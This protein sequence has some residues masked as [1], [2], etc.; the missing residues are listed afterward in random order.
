MSPGIALN[1]VRW[2]VQAFGGIDSLQFFG[3]EPFL[4]PKLM[5]EVC[6]YLRVLVGKGNLRRMPRLAVVTNG[7]LGN[8]RIIKLLKRYGIAVTVSIDG[9]ESVHDELRGKGSFGL[10]DAFARKARES[11]LTTDF[12]CTWTALHVARGI[13]M[14]DLVEFFSAR[15]DM[16]LLHV[17]PVS[18]PPGSRLRIDPRTKREGLKEAARYSVRTLAAGD[19]RA[20]SYSDRVIKALLHRKAIRQYCP[21]GAGTLAVS[22]DGGVYPCFM[23][24]GDARFRICRLSEEEGIGEGNEK[25]VSRLIKSY[26]KESHRDC[27]ACWAKPLCNSCIGND[28]IETGSIGRHSSCDSI[29]AIAESVLMEIAEIMNGG[30][31]RPSLE[32]VPDL[33]DRGG[34]SS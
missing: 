27:S 19:Y 11:G 2:A 31:K 25:N 16:A 3:G 7:T 26:G 24:V 5:I 1:S 29:R 23:F 21:A 10:A 12:E 15:Y 4:N 17:V 22:A 33:P 8:E 32:P 28:L 14:V 9:P 30:E 13:S 6:E 18:A 34:P 20:N